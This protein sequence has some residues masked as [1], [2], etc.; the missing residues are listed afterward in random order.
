MIKSLM[1]TGGDILTIINSAFFILG[2]IAVFMLG[3]NML[4]SNIEKAAGKSMRRLMGKATKN[5]FIGVG[6]GAA[7]TVICNS[8]SATTVMIVGFVNVGLMTLTQAA[9]VIMGANIGTTI[10]AFVMALSSVG[11][12]QLSIAAVFALVA[13]VGFVFTIA[14][15]NE[16]LKQ[17]GTIL[18]GVGVIFVGLNVMSSAVNGMLDNPNVETA[19]KGLFTSLGNGDKALTWEIPV[20]FCLGALLTGLMQSSGALTAIVISLASRFEPCS[21]HQNSAE[22]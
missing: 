17:I 12:T 8:S 1:L 4:G 2:G 18:E 11:G 7:I 16:K 20:L 9:S 22:E 19:V 13:F 15:K 5:R 21:S 14:G 3:M 10:S 6:T